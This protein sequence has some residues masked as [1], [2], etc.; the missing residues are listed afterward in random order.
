MAKQERIRPVQIE[1][2]HDW[3]IQTEQEVSEHEKEEA[4]NRPLK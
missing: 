2:S 1:P 3:Q 4:K